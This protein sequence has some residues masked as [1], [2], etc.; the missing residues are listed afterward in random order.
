[1]FA[2]LPACVTLLHCT[3]FYYLATQSLPLTACVVSYI[4]LLTALYAYLPTY[5][6]ASLSA[7]CHVQITL[8]HCLYLP[9]NPHAGTSLLHLAYLLCCLILWSL[10][11]LFTFLTVITFCISYISSFPA[12]L[13]ACLPSFLPHC[14]PFYLLARLLTSLRVGLTVSHLCRCACVS[15]RVVSCRPG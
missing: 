14:L 15:C 4:S 3:T 7:L 5:P 13:S 2:S 6:L 8:A 1:M 10:V 9:I 11:R 12:S